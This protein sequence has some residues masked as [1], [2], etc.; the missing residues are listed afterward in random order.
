M[1]GAIV[2]TN[3]SLLIGAW[4]HLCVM[5]NGKTGDWKLYVNGT[6]SATEK[7]FISQT[8]FNDSGYMFLG[9]LHEFDHFYVFLYRRRQ[10]YKCDYCLL[11]YY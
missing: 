1:N 9:K 5:L 8:F 7:I 4:N 10:Y 3:A 2:E 11:Y 6:L